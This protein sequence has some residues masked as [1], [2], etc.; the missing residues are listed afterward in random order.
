MGTMLDPQIKNPTKKGGFFKMFGGKS[1]GA[2]STANK[3]QA[4]NAAGGDDLGQRLEGAEMKDLRSREANTLEEQMDFFTQ[5][6]SKLLILRRQKREVL[7]ATGELISF[8]GLPTDTTSQLLS[9]SLV[10]ADFLSLLCGADKNETKALRAKVSHS[11]SKGD[12]LNI[13][14]GIRQPSKKRF[15]SSPNDKIIKY[16]TLFLTPLKDRENANYAL[17]ALFA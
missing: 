2:S 6:S 4:L 17:V 3:K 9:S 10:H 13:E 14:V 15:G 12:A 16:T 11:I 8:F 7:F 5:Q 1:N